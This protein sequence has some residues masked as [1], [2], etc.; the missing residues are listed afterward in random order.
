M[1][2]NFAGGG[3]GDQVFLMPPDPRE[4]LPEGHL[5]WAMRR[6]AGELDLARF[7]A[8]Y[9]ADGQGKMAY[10]P[11][12][13]VAL[14]MYCY[15]KGI[16]SSRAIEMATWD[17]VGAR[18]ICGGLHPDH[19]T[20]ARFVARHKEPLKGL[21]VASL[22]VCAREGLVRV[23]VAAGDGTKVKANAS[24]AANVTAGQLGLDITELEK[25]LEAEVAAWIEQA[26]V[27]DAAEDALFGGDDD[28]GPPA[29]GPPARATRTR[30]AGKLARR[31]AA[32]AKLTAAEQARRQQAGAER[33][34]KITRLA[35]RA[36]RLAARAAAE[37]ARAQAKVDRYAQR[38]AAAA[39]CGKRPGGHVP[40]PAAR[41]RDARAAAQAAARAARKLDEAIAT[42]AAAPA[43][44]RPPKANTTDPASRVM[45]IKKG[46]WDQQYNLQALAGRGQVILAIA[47]HD[48]TNDLAALHPLLA[49]AT[50]SLAAA[51]LPATLG[52]AL[53]DAG[54][55]SDANFTTGCAAD[56]YVA[57]T[58][59]SA[60]TGNGP[61]GRDPA[62]IQ[63]WQQMAAK[64]DT[65]EGRALY[66]QRKAIIE[67]VFAQLF[68]RFGRTLHYRGD[69]V[70]T[71][72]HLWAAVHNTLK[73]IRARTRREH[74]ERQAAAPPALA[75]A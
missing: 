15:A 64:L 74:R 12:M 1:G 49:T 50:A 2:Y 25:L 27:V 53:F 39:R 42:P 60:Q 5:A 28:G 51:G 70:S 52:T 37:L 4:W 30:T 32:R 72:I 18:V 71:E 68:A 62:A 34:D 54:Y 69:M 48:S 24:M 56:L 13:M 16:Q 33:Q 19:A 41:Q 57:V 55:A 36:E 73:A 47:T 17:D 46:G 14:I 3:D 11:R 22:V 75:T 66:K 61:A 45:P 26:H 65:P 35:A 6:A 40:A 43:P 29:G 21:L 67:P 58:R 23:D 9:R 8:S 63:S 31:Q 7:L 38:T 10:H 20:N 59:E 44:A